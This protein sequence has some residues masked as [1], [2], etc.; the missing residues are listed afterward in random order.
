M[1]RRTFIQ[2]LGATSAYLAS[3]K[4]FAASD[5][6]SNPEFTCQKIWIGG[7]Y[8]ELW[9]KNKVIYMTFYPKDNTKI[10]Y[11]M[12]HKMVD[13]YEKK[14]KKLGPDQNAMHKILGEFSRMD[15][16]N[17]NTDIVTRHWFCNDCVYLL[18]EVQYLK[19]NECIVL[20]Q[21]FTDIWI[22][23]NEDIVEDIVTTD[24]PRLLADQIKIVTTKSNN[25]FRISQ[26]NKKYY[27][28]NSK[29]EWVE[30][31]SKQENVIF[32]YFGDFRKTTLENQKL[33]E[34]KRKK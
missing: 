3:S 18:E 6:S 29:D 14:I 13:E 10:F 30:K 25:S 22:K 23:N 24:C 17:P 2:L 28:L 32:D 19:D 27:S 7:G 12:K 16:I 4:S 9:R 34:K 26:V 31:E 5:V 15:I 21:K 8:F 1:L 33:L 20:S 11:K